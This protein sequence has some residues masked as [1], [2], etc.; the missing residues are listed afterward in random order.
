[1]LKI[2]KPYR[3]GSQ[4]INTIYISIKGSFLKTAKVW[5]VHLAPQNL[6]IREISEEEITSIK[7]HF[8]ALLSVCIPGVYFQTMNNINMNHS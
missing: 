5:F 8:D 7:L 4:Y 6:Q 1:M 3:E 2:S